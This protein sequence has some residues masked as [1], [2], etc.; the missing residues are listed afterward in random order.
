MPPFF[1][2]AT[3]PA[4]ALGVTLCAL[5]LIRA[6][7]AINRMGHLSP[8]LLVRLAFALLVTGAVAGIIA[9]LAGTVPDPHTL[10]ILAGTAALTF[11]ERRLRILSGTNPRKGHP[12]AQ[13]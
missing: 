3:T 6:E 7:P 12:H 5:I 11:C 1:D 2:I 4:Q 13:R 10:I 9:I 8:P